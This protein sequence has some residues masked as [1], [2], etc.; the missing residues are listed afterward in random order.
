MA[1]KTASYGFHARY[2]AS[3]LETRNCVRKEISM[4]DLPSL[5][6]ALITTMESV[7]GVPIAQLERIDDTQQ[8]WVRSAAILCTKTGDPFC[9]TDVRFMTSNTELSGMSRLIQYKV[10]D[11]GA[12]KTVCALLPPIPEIDPTYVADAFATG[13]TSPDQYPS[14]QVTAQWLMLYHAAHCMDTQ[15]NQQ[16]ED[17]AKAFATLGI[18]M[19]QGSPSFTPGI[20]RS[21]WR[22]MATLSGSTPAYWAAGTG[23]RILLDLWKNQTASILQTKYNCDARIAVNTS[24]DIEKISREKRLATGQDCSP[25]AASGNNNAQSGR[26]N[27]I[28][29]DSNLWIWMYGNGGLGAPP[30]S[31]TPMAAWGGDYK[32]GY[33][34]IWST[35]SQLA[36]M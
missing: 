4:A 15:F 30:V 36:G 13:Y 31:Y 7:S 3:I 21:E 28:V 24:I 20:Q 10:G 34:Y 33:A 2:S 35:A 22:A 5:V 27:G 25:T 17:R 18:A 8:F 19:L 26:G 1:A 6:L 12:T 29:S 23:E 11:T 16:E 9:D 32:K 14:N